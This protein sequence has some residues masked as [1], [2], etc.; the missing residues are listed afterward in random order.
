[1]TRLCRDCLDLQ[2][3]G[4]AEGACRRCGGHRMLSHPELDDLGIA[5]I[6]CDAFYASIE[7]RD[8]PELRD[9]PVVV[10]GARRGVV[11]AA[12]YI[13]RLYGVRSAMPMFKALQACPDAVVIKPDMAK[14]Q[15]VGRAI[16]QRMLALTPLVEPLSIDEAYLDLQGTEIVHGG[17]P[18]LSLARLALE[19]ERDFGLTVSVGL[20]SNKFLAKIASDL[21]KPR[22]FA[23]I[24]RAEAQDFLADKPVSLIWGV[25]KALA[26]RL[27]RDG[28][29]R[30]ADLL[31]I[32]E[33]E[34]VARYGAMG[35]RL[36]R[37]ARGEDSRRVEPN[38]PTKSIS[39]E[40]T[41]NED[42]SEAADLERALWP[43]CE[44]VARRLRRQ[45]LLGISVTL[46]L[47]TADFRQFTRS[48]RLSTP[49]YLAE[50][51]FRAGREMVRANADGRR[52]R[53]IGI[54]L[55][56]F[57]REEEADQLSLLDA[58]V[59]RQHRLEDAM[60]QVRE[61][62]GSTAIQRGRSLLA[63][64]RRKPSA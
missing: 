1:M 38:A 4:T 19:I 31:P 61:K 36:Y 7:K 25:G 32:P 42:L 26:R 37:F 30:I 64:D 51:I 3:A 55:S 34:L 16:R 17:P 2:P 12:C 62:S 50:I 33:T 52:F 57:K 40:T 11:A 29:R 18:A 43:L 10:G 21:D 41:F 63:N 6:D 23:V 49:T 48:H 45:G 60:A 46:K 8:R 39:A 59:L 15:D 9:R 44:T 22:G 58:D 53:L 14:Y 35:R 56:D 5:H 27:E 20:S 28:I 54:G 47:K 24:G 13:A